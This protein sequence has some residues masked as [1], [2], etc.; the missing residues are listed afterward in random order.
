MMN[1]IKQKCI[2]TSLIQRTI[3]NPIFR[4]V[5]MC[6]CVLAILVTMIVPTWQVYTEDGRSSTLISYNEPNT[7]GESLFVAAS[8]LNVD[9]ENKRYTINFSI[10]PNGTLSNAYGQLT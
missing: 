6:L 8:A 9:F 5:L 7:R 2:E 3:K 4:R 10:Q 1:T